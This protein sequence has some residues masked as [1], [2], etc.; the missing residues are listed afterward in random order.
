M[1]KALCCLPVFVVACLP[2]FGHDERTAAPEKRAD[3]PDE[4]LLKRAGLQL[5]E[6]K[7]IAYLGLVHRFGHFLPKASLWTGR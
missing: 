2:L 3:T 4:A 1:R 6:D 5:T 7:L